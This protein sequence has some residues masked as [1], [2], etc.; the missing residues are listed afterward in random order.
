MANRISAII[1]IIDS[2]R[3]FHV[4]SEDNPADLASR[5]VYP[6]ELVDNSLWW[7]G[8]TWLKASPE[9]WKSLSFSNVDTDIERKPVKCHSTL[10]SNHDDPL[11]RFSSLARAFRCLSYAYRFFF[12]TH[13]HHKLSAKYHS[14]EVSIQE[15]IFVRDR[16]IVMTQKVAFSEEYQCLAAKRPIPTSS[17]ILCLNPFLSDNYIIRSCGR[18]EATSGLTYDEKH[19]IILPYNCQYSRLLVR[20]IHEISLHG[21]NQLVLRLLREQFWI[22]RVKNLIRATIN[23]CK[24]CVLYKQKCQKQ[25]MAAL[26]KE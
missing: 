22:P 18:L 5:G 8:P 7:H 17:S 24:P 26:P 19:P 12:R 20:F 25:L 15:I 23:Q 11:S 13:P 4:A 14:K 6:Q 3:W 9:A 1:Q 10:I 16:L 2:D 21:G